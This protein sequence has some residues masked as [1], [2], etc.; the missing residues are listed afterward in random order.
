M[1]RIEFS[2][3]LE[4]ASCG[5]R[6]ELLNRGSGVRVPAPAPFLYSESAAGRISGLLPYSHRYSQATRKREGRERISEFGGPLSA[7]EREL[8]QYRRVRMARLQDRNKSAGVP[9]N[10]PR[11]LPAAAGGGRRDRPLP[12][13]GGGEP[14]S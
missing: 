1:R 9:G 5:V 13:T 4:E 6:G 8:R 3:R 12:A 14:L 11:L 2:R 7:T 10:P